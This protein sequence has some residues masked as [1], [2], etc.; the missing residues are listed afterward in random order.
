MA[1][2]VFVVYED[3]TTR[4]VL[5]ENVERL[6]KG[7]PYLIA[8]VHHVQGN[9]TN[10]LAFGGDSIL[11]LKN[12]PTVGLLVKQYDPADA[13]SPERGQE[14][15]LFLDGSQIINRVLPRNIADQVAVG[16]DVSFDSKPFSDPDYND[17]ITLA[18]AIDPGN[19][20]P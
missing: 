9:D 7:V 19:P 6:P 13:G 18:N 2:S 8:K 17:K 4:H 11:A 16:A 15:F 20:E 3:L 5:W 12:V 10:V 1:N 14:S